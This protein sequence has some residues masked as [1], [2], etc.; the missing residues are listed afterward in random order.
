MSRVGEL[1]LFA[2]ELIED[3]ADGS[4]D[5]DGAVAQLMNE[6]GVD[7]DDAEFILDEVVADQ[8]S[9]L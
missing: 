4:I 7:I 3:V 8:E 2:S 5:Y 9:M 6:Y 1:Y